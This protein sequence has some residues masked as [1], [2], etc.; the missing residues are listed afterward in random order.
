[1]SKILEKKFIP[2]LVHDFY[3]VRLNVELY[4][5][6][7]WLEL[8]LSSPV[9]L[10]SSLGLKIDPFL[11]AIVSALFQLGFGFLLL[12]KEDADPAKLRMVKNVLTELKLCYVKCW[13]FLKYYLAT[14]QY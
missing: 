8:D 6:V 13:N 10:Y 3:L 14:S 2:A 1:M 5:I 12:N 9:T 7:S 11:G 4:M